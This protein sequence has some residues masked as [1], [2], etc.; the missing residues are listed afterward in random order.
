MD[1]LM[2]YNYFLAR[3]G[4]RPVLDLQLQIKSL[5]VKIVE[6]MVSGG[7]ALAVDCCLFAD[8]FCPNIYFNLW[9]STLHILVAVD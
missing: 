9:H 4:S 8:E 7:L 6:I 1:L 3:P 5:Q 2:E